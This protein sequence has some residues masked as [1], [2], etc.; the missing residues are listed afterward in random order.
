MRSLPDV[1]KACGYTVI[2]HNGLT[3]MEL[4][5]NGDW[6]RVE[7]A[8]RRFV[9]HSRIYDHYTVVVRNADGT[10]D[11]RD[12]G[13]NQVRFAVLPSVAYRWIQRKGEYSGVRKS[14][15]KF[16]GRIWVGHKEIYIGTY[17]DAI[18]AAK[19][20]DTYVIGHGLTMRLNFP[21]TTAVLT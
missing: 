12:V 20:R 15:K 18:T 16:M 9:R 8:C 10:R 4:A 6:M 21:N 7:K 5:G 1:A 14:G 17:P 19:A 11:L 13:L 3:V 2:S